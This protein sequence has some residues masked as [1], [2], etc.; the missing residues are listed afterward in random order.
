M[1]LCV[2]ATD[3][4]PPSVCPETSVKVPIY[5][6]NTMYKTGAGTL[7]L[8][9]AMTFGTNNLC[10]VRE[11]GMTALADA[12]VEGLDCTFADGTA[13]V[14]SPDS[15]AA[16]GFRKVTVE[17]AEGG[18]AGQVNVQPAMPPEG[19]DD[20]VTFPICT[21]PAAD[22]DLTDNLVLTRVRHYNATLVKESVT[23]GGVAS[24]RYLAHYVKEGLTILFR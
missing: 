9:G 8:G 3:A 6:N 16:N 7:A 5:Q 2:S 13:I 20:N 24:T 21:V 11:G 12:A 22:A 10:R 18:A 19:I 15:T 14:L 4:M 23:V 1:P 17:E